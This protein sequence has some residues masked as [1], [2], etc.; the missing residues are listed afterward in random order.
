MDRAHL[1]AWDRGRS[2]AVIRVIDHPVGSPADNPAPTYARLRHAP[3]KVGTP[4]PKLG[5]DTRDVLRESGHSDQEIDD[6]VAAGI[7]AE[8]LHEAYLPA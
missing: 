8:Q 7:A 5:G 1:D 6:L 4:T 2:I 3:L